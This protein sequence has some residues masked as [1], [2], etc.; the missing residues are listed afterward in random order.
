MDFCMCCSARGYFQREL[1]T[2]SLG[3]FSNSASHCQ[4]FSGFGDAIRVRKKH[5]HEG[6]LGASRLFGKCSSNNCA[7]RG[8]Q[9]VRPYEFRRGA[10][11]V[12]SGTAL[13]CPLTLDIMPP[14]QYR[15]HDTIRDFEHV[16]T[17]RPLDKVI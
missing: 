6:G 13:A 14:E 10:L 8:S 1:D 12:R 2:K 7:N 4:P 5:Y 11:V 3:A 17:A 16:W 15:G 9:R